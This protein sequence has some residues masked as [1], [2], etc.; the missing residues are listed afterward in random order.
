[1]K[2]WSTV[3]SLAAF[4]AAYASSVSAQE[5]AKATFYYESSYSDVALDF[6]GRLNSL[7][8]DQSD[9]VSVETQFIEISQKNLAGAL[10][11]G[12]IIIGGVGAF[13]F[14]EGYP[15][16]LLASLKVPVFY[17][18]TRVSMELQESDLGQAVL[19]SLSTNGII[20]IGFLN[21]G[22]SLVIADE[23]LDEISSL[24]GKKV[25]VAFG[26]TDEGYW[27][28]YGATTVGI[29]SKNVAMAV[30]TGSVDTVE[31]FPSWTSIEATLEEMGQ[32][33]GMAVSYGGQQRTAVIATLSSSWDDFSFLTRHIL[34]TTIR[35][36]SR[37]LGSVV[38]E[39]ELTTLAKFPEP[40]FADAQIA[41]LVQA[42]ST[43][44]SAN[45]ARAS[46]AKIDFIYETSQPFDRS[47]PPIP[48]K[49]SFITNRGESG[50]KNPQIFFDDS[51]KEQLICGYFTSLGP[52]GYD[53]K[54][55]IN[56]RGDSCLEWI[57]SEVEDTKPLLYIHGY[58]NY[59]FDAALQATKIHRSYVDKNIILWSWPSRG[60]VFDYSYD[61]K[62][63][64][65]SFLHDAIAKTIIKLRET[66][67]ELDII[68][69]SLGGE[70]FLNAS[71]N[72]S[73][74]APSK[75]IRNIIL[76]A[77]D[78]STSDFDG[79]VGRILTNA[80]TINLYTCET[81]EALFISEGINHEP[82]LGLGGHGNRVMYDGLYNIDVAGRP[83]RLNH[84]YV[85]SDD[86]VVSDIGD[87]LHG[88]SD[89]ATRELNQ[90]RR[91]SNVYY[92]FP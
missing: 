45:I 30:T 14:I 92:R 11:Q 39:N 27:E 12:G 60:E 24:G 73:R 19:S 20:G 1:M 17:K 70:V 15:Q 86:Q 67:T 74:I 38:A 84:G 71:Y 44:Q 35:D 16:D 87:V 90:H 48:N 18:P 52:R 79:S 28:Q 76:A 42:W 66:S 46:A 80:E 4:V 65:R 64:G 61:S 85:F 51:R 63:A 49:I 31:L 47:L 26:N 13:D 89:A 72:I 2:Y 32:F 54:I 5:V 88:L 22:A 33:E 59:F 9:I 25:A 82:R 53:S 8:K 77:P 56:A 69:H 57:K 21:A 41:D 34:T 83:G 91:G 37:S 75:V 36:A 58:N 3:L 7:L 55:E 43:A 6:Q 78:V 62:S 29:D 68:V 40:F 23:P 50:S 10:E 81:D